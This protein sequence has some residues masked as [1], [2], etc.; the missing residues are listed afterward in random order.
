MRSFIIPISTAVCLFAGVHAAP[1]AQAPDLTPSIGTVQ[2]PTALNKL[3]DPQSLIGS[4]TGSAGAGGSSDPQKRSTYKCSPGGDDACSPASAGSGGSG[5]DPVTV[6]DTALNL[7][8]PVTAGTS[9]AVGN[10]LMGVGS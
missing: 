2:G 3:T 4:L 6:V 7:A 5:L 8:N 9:D 10:M 1:A